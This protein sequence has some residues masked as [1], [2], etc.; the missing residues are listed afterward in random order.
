MP[1]FKHP[2]TGQKIIV[3]NAFEKKQQKLPKNQKEKAK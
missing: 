3:T 2:L 1:L